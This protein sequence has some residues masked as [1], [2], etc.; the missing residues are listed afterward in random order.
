MQTRD[1]VKGLHNCQE[2]SKTLLFRALIK[3][4]ILTSRE[5]LYMKLACIISPTYPIEQNRTKNQS[6]PI[7]LQSFDWVGQ[8]NKIEHLFCCEFDFRTNRTNIIEQNRTNPMQLSLDASN[9]VKHVEYNH[10]QLL[11]N[12]QELN[13]ILQECQC[14]NKTKQIKGN[15]DDC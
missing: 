1:K 14:S 12:K 4:E 15:F 13:I 7:E 6:N 3:R 8:S 11:L 2:K 5:V 10:C 9:W